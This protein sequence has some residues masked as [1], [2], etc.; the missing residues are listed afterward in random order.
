MKGDIHSILALLQVLSALG[1]M[2]ENY[3]RHRLVQS[4][5]GGNDFSSPDMQIAYIFKY[6]LS[7]SNVVRGALSYCGSTDET[8][9]LAH[10]L[11]QTKILR[12][13]SIGGGPG[14]E[15]LGLLAH[16][17]DYDLMHC[18]VEACLVDVCSGWFGIQQMAAETV[19]ENGWQK[20][21][22]TPVKQNVLDPLSTEL[23]DKVR[24]CD[25]ITFVKV[26][27]TAS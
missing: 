19:R 1:K 24:K 6:M 20:V 17:R 13:V 3:T 14:S 5:D 7:H 16:L 12:V 21:F 9:E 18:S 26:S 22:L 15:F 25:I 23:E 10:A 11:T 4:L 2:L 8:P 27:V